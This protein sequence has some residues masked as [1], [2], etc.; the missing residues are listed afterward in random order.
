[1]PTVKESA[2]ITITSATRK[3]VKVAFDAL[4]AQFQ[5]FAKVVITAFKQVTAALAG[6]VLS[7]HEPDRRQREPRSYP[8]VHATFDRRGRRR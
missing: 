4:V 5:G 1:M 7:T 3:K 2:V 8:G 6:L